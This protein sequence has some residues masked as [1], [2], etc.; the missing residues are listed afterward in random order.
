MLE[1]NNTYPNFIKYM[2][3]KT[4]LLDFIM[5][6]IKSAY[7][8]GG[9][10]VDL[11]AGSATLSG[12]LRGHAPVISNDIQIYSK[13]LAETY[14]NNY[15]WYSNLNIID[16]VIAAATKKYNELI[17]SHGI[18]TDQFMYRSDMTIEEFKL[19]E[20][21]QREL[22]NKDSWNGKY[23]LFA[24]YYSGTY[25]TYE[26]CV[27]I[28]S[29]RYVADTF[30]D[31][32]F[33]SAI[34]TALM[35]AMSYNAQSTGHYAQYREANTETSMK[36]IM[37]YRNKEITPYVK[38]K[39]IELRD[40]MSH[41]HGFNYQTMALDFKDCLRNIPVES[42]VYADP[43]Y[44]FVHYSRF[45]H[46]IETLVK[47]D[48]PDIKF[49]GRYRTD[50][51]QSPFCIKTKVKNAFKDMFELISERKSNLVLS[52]SN[53][54]M[55]SIEEINQLASKTLKGY[56]IELIT[57]DYKHSTMGRRIDKFKNVQEALIVIKQN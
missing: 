7:I 6:G 34:L 30:Q 24:K 1:Y 39:L 33:S 29:Y 53:T 50:R 27:W 19:I 49:K 28:D 35:F 43:P 18:A 13:I 4:N 52:Y 45:Y 37:I 9:T 31:K 51:H 38:R 55:I 41:T 54:G 22:I 15:D 32:T 21:A 11:F 46:T 36:D 25:W 8:D 44:C 12:A 2:G 14:L 10:V 16:D 23:Y 47:Y 56:S 42:T 48:Y 5:S 17:I 26:Q 57:T 3:S 20:E 40:S